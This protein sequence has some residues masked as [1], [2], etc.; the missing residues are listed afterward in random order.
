VP[1][2]ARC[3]FW[4]VPHGVAVEVVVRAATPNVRQQVENAL[5]EHCVPVQALHLVEDARQLRHPLPLRCDL[6][7]LAFSSSRRRDE[8]VQALG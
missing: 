7:E 1:L 4:A 8:V 2:P 5:A 6:Q 3:G